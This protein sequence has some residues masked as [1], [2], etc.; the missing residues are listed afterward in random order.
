MSK[1][2]YLYIVVFA[3]TMGG[4]A[5]PMVDNDSFI[6]VN[7]CTYHFLPLSRNELHNSENNYEFSY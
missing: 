6:W 4:T 2:R 1:I 7:T 5:E 3:L